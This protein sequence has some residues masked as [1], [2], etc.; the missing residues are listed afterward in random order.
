MQVEEYLN[1]HDKDIVYEVSDEDQIILD[2]VEMFR[3]RP[4]EMKHKN[5]EEADDS[6]ENKIINPNKALKS[7]ENVCTFLL[8]KEGASECIKLVSMIK[9]FIIAKKKDLMK[10]FTID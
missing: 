6:I 3:E 2:L 7:L 8:Q 9:K 5:F 1:I 10:Q 4:D